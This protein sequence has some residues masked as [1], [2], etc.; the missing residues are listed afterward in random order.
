M[1]KIIQNIEIE[2]SKGDIANQPDFEAVGNA[3][4][5]EP[6]AGEGVAGAIHRTAAKGLY[7]ECK[8]LALIASGEAVI[9]A[10]HNLPNKYLIHCLSP[11]YGGD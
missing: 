7:K 1:K 8:L 9:T 3:A 10:A 5:A 6:S 11:V 4:N 2:V